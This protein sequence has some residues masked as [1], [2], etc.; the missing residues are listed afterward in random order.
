M[1]GRGG[2]ASL[3]Q[4][5]RVLSDLADHRRLAEA[6]AGEGGEHRVHRA[7][8]AGHQQAAAGLRVRKQGLMHRV[9]TGRL[10]RHRTQVE[11]EDATVGHAVMAG[12]VDP[13]V[14]LVDRLKKGKERLDSAIEALVLL[15]NFDAVLGENGLR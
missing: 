12:G 7:G 2:G 10:R 13:A 6:V 9:E 15:W 1:G 3:D 4:M 14:L 8:F 11:F 5:R